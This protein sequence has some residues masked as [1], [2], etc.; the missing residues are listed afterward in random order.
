M[1]PTGLAIRFFGG[2]SMPFVLLLLVFCSALD[3]AA[4]N[5]PRFHGPKGQGRSSES[6]LPVKW[7]ASTNVRWKTPLPGPGHSS[8]IVWEDRIFLTAFRKEASALSFLSSGGDVVVLSIDAAS[9][10]IL[11]ER[12][13]A[14]RGIEET[15]S[16]N[17][18]ASPT[19]VTDGERVYVYFG[20][21]GLICFDFAGKKIWEHP[22]GP[23]PNEW[24]SASSPSFT[25]T[26]FCST[27][28][29]TA[30]IFCSR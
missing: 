30:K 10:K 3:L 16:A 13:V 26:S 7:S 19:P 8:P 4:K 6:N 28:T 22:L 23:F 17:A 14:A 5:W 29:P 11:W 21:F 27:S 2:R 24:G 1:Q 25:M 9:G 20:S 12:N 18:P 15:H